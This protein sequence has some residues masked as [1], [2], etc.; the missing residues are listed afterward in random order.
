M[1]VASAVPTAAIDCDFHFDEQR[2]RIRVASVIG[3]GA[4]GLSE[5]LGRQKPAKPD[6]RSGSRIA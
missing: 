2:A 4:P 3:I 1:T 5:G 6:A